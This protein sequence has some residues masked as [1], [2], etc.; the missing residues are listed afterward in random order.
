MSILVHRT[1]VRGPDDFPNRVRQRTCRNRGSKGW[2]EVAKIFEKMLQ[3]SGV[4]D[5]VDAEV[6]DDE[7]GSPAIEDQRHDNALFLGRLR[8][9]TNLMASGIARK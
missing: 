1:E 8:V 6:V 5:V 9:S 2:S 3:E 4:G 7:S